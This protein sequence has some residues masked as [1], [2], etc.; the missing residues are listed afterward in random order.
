MSDAVQLSPEEQLAAKVKKY[1]WPLLGVAAVLVAG[2][3]GGL[4]ISGVEALFALA[5]AGVTAAVCVY[6]LPVI[7]FKLANARMK[8][9]VGEA[10]HNPIETLRNDYIYRQ[11]QLQ[12]ADDSI[13]EFEMEIR[14]YDDQ[15]REFKEQYPD[16][17]ENFLEISQAMHDG[18]REM[19]S[20][21]AIARAAVADLAQKIKKAE[22]IYKM[23]LAAQRVTS[24][25]RDSQEKVFA[26]I[27][28]QVAFDA[29][30]SQLN[31]SFAALDRAMAKRTEL[32]QRAAAPALPA[33]T[34]TDTLPAQV[35][36]PEKV[37]VIR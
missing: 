5:A 11:N 26:D 6:F 17:A 34:V 4:I 24:L 15:C 18:L 28:Q 30:R 33:T 22:A 2:E 29:V 3:F 35:I 13:Q 1:K 37:R 20:E 9:I 19:K 14:N 10:E 27:K 23:S 16:E 21:Q 7:T 32:S 25:S 8:M 31:R 12:R 36:T